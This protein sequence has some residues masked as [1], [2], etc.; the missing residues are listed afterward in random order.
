MQKWLT[1]YQPKLSKNFDIKQKDDYVSFQN[2]VGV[3][4]P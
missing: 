4:L 3:G 2:H 1:Y